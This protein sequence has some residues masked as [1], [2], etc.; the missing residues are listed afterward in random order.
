[1]AWLD[2]QFEEIAR[3]LEGRLA[4]RLVQQHPVEVLDGGGFEFKQFHRRLHR[5]RDRGEEDQAQALLL[6]QGNDVYFG[7]DD[8]RQRPFAAAQQVVEVIRLPHAALNRIA[9]PAL[10]QPRRPA[11]RYAQTV[12]IEQ[13]TDQ[14][15]LLAQCVVFGRHQHHATVGHDHL[16]FAD[17]VSRG[18][19]DR[20]PRAAGVV[21]NHAAQRGAG[22]GRHIRPEPE[23]VRPQE[24]VELI[25]YHPRPHPHRPALQIQICDLA[26]MA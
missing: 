23:L 17:M 5:L 2:I 26:V 21:R 10:R 12:E 7:R 16:Q 13:V 24:V 20:R 4:F 25:Q 19:I 6:R 15:A 18:A 8:D 1:M 11:L 9:R 22:T 3:G 14:L